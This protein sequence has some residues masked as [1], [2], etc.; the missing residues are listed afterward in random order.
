LPV[1]WSHNS[2]LQTEPMSKYYSSSDSCHVPV[3]PP[4]PVNGYDVPGWYGN[5]WFV[6]GECLSNAASNGKGLSAITMVVNAGV[7]SGEGGLLLLLLSLS[8]SWLLLPLL[9][10]RMMLTMVA[11]VSGEGGSELTMTSKN[12][13]L[14]VVDR[15]SI[16]CRKIKK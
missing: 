14:E 6:S 2:V 9:F 10:S 13:E 7:Y 8:L 4:A 11:I 3:P 12:R 15:L 5:G 1:S 16:G